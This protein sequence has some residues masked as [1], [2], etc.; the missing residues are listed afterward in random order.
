MAPSTSEDEFRAILRT[1]KRIIVIAG[2]GLSAASGTP[3]LVTGL[4]SLITFRAT[5]C[6]HIY[7]Y[8]LWT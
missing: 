7:L 4:Q 8:G 6:Y 1:S 2:A 3:V 5:S